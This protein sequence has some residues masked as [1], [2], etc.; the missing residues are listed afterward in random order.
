[1]A[2]G[3]NL[4]V[5]KFENLGRWLMDG[6]DDGF[7]SSSHLLQHLYG[8]DRHERIKTRCRLIA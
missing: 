5:K 3:L 7:A 1:M 4:L 6:A 2:S 8:L